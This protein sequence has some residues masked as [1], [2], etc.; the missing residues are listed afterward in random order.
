MCS[1]ADKNTLFCTFCTPMYVHAT[2][3]RTI[4]RREE[5]NRWRCN[6]KHEK[7]NASK[8]NTMS[9]SSMSCTFSSTSSGG[10]CMDCTETSAAL[11]ASGE[12]KRPKTGGGPKVEPPDSP[13]SCWMPKD[14]HTPCDFRLLLDAEMTQIA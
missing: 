3:G 7:E 9:C 5:M 10:Q 14:W 1:I 11:R 6:E 12:A 2:C 8:P 13:T 4:R